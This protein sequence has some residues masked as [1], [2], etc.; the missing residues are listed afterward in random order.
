MIRKLWDKLTG[1]K[2]DPRPDP[3]DSTAYTHADLVESLQKNRSFP[4]QTLHG[5][6]K[7]SDVADRKNWIDPPAGYENWVDVY[8][9]P[10]GIGYVVNYEVQR[11]GKPWQ[12]AINYGPE[13]WREQDWTEVV[14]PKILTDR[15]DIGR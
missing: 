8:E 11:G 7:P 1:R 14:E 4:L 15:M 2:A 6:G 10:K 5:G 9:G 12:K 3:E 13:D